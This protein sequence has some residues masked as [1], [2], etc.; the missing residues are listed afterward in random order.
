MDEKTERKDKCKDL[1]RDAL[2]GRA[3][4]LAKLWKLYQQGDES[5]PDLGT[6]YEYGLA[7]DYVAPGTFNGQKRGYFRYQLSYGGPSEEFR[8]FT[9]E[10]FNPVRIEFWF[11]DWFDGAKVT[12][13][14][15]SAHDRLLRDLWDWFKEAGS[16]QAEFDKA[17]R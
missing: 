12:L 3:E 4:D 13:K 1:V 16:V 15:G 17:G 7:F 5:D 8:F 11:L 6:L 10:N 2:K 9:D 14:E